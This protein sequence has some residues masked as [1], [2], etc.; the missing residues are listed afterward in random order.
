MISPAAL[1]LLV[2]L[3]TTV[4]AQTDSCAGQN[5]IVS[6]L[7]QLIETKVNDTLLKDSLDLLVNRIEARIEDRVNRTLDS[8]LE[9]RI[10]SI[11]AAEPGE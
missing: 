8:Q 2:V 11:L 5:N 3:A 10:D 7:D 6:V 1:L 9:G 4:S